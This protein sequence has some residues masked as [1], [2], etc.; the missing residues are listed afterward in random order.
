MPLSYLKNT[1]EQK[2]EFTE[3]LMFFFLAKFPLFWHLSFVYKSW[4]DNREQGFP[5]RLTF[6]ELGEHFEQNS[7]KLHENYKINIYRL[8][9][10]W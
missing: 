5:N 1:T 7:Q 2:E 6:W 9:A 3:S 4:E 8:R 10:K